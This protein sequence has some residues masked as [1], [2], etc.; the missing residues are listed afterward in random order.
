MKNFFVSAVL[1]VL[2]WVIFTQVFNSNIRRNIDVLHLNR[3]LGDPRLD[4][5]KRIDILKILADS[6]SFPQ[7]LVAAQEVE[8]YQKAV[9]HLQQ[10]G[11]HLSYSPGIQLLYNPEFDPGFQHWI[12]YNS[13]WSLSTEPVGDGRSMAVYSRTGAGQS[14][15][16]QSLSLTTGEC[17]LFTVQAAVVREDSIPTYWLYWE[18]YSE[19][20]I[21]TGKSILSTVGSQPWTTYADIFCLPQTSNAVERV[22]LAPVNLYGDATVYIGSARLYL[23]NSAEI[24][25]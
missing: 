22:T 13:S 25:Q 5:E 12:Q 9:T 14:S 4:L 20:N 23:L 24:E 7:K 19:D 17:Y 8:A 2:T 6:T 1:L 15:L 18:T 11:M 16:S 21:P 10:E 3:S